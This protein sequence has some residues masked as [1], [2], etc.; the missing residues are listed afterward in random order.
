[1]I[2][3]A[4]KAVRGVHM[5]I[6]A[7]VITAVVLCA[8]ETPDPGRPRAEDPQ[9]VP[10]RRL[11][12]PADLLLP[13]RPVH[14]DLRRVRL[15]GPVRRPSRVHDR[16]Q[17]YDAVPGVAAPPLLRSTFSATWRTPRSSYPD[18]IWPGQAAEAL[19]GLI[20]A[21]NTARANGLAAVPDDAAAA[22]VL[23]EVSNE[24][25]GAHPRACV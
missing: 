15:P 22:D 11:H 3:R 9:E 13:R 25:R 7:L 4:A 18:A 8:D 20:H 24:A 21:A 12:E 14:E 23:H 17:N 10:A 5:L 2:A 19:R 1:M 16:Y 6:R